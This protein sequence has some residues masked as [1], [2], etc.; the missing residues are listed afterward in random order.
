[1]TNLDT[2]QSANS[3]GASVKPEGESAN[4]TVKMALD[5]LHRGDHRAISHYT[6]A[7]LDKS[8][9]G[10]NLSGENLSG[11]DLSH[12]DLRGANL[13]RARLDST[14]L[15]GADL[16]NTTI[17]CALMERTAMQNA[18]LTNI[19]SHAMSVV[20]SDWRGVQ[21]QGAID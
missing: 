17:I 13:T 10:L 8:E 16:S 20:S 14:K 18:R 9:V 19:Y 7:T 3:N 2:A 11:L 15:V 6:Q 21:M 12:A 1:M 4:D 5:A